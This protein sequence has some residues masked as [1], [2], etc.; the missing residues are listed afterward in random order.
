MEIEKVKSPDL[1]VRIVGSELAVDR[2]DCAQDTRLRDRP[3]TDREK[4]VEPVGTT[5]H[6][7][8]S[9]QGT[10]IGLKAAHKRR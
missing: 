10:Q 9:W 8:V 4:H 7:V 1:Y 5:R 3:P 2:L 6:G